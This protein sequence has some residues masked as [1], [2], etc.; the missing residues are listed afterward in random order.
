MKVISIIN[1]KGGVGKTTTAICLAAGLANK[2][3]KILLVDLDP[4]SSLTLSLGAMDTERNIYKVFNE[5]LKFSEVIKPYKNFHLVTSDIYLAGIERRPELDTY[6]VI[7]ESLGEINDFDYVLIDCPPSLGILT[8]NSLVSS[9]YLLIPL[10]T[11]YLAVRGLD[12]LIHTYQHTKKKHNQKLEIMGVV[13]TMFD[14]RRSLDK[15]TI[16]TL[17]KDKIHKFNTIIRRSVDLAEAPLKQMTIFDYH[18]EGRGASDYND[19]TKE[20]L[21]WLK[22][23]N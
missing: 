11:E 1:Q 15:V 12:D 20:V 9:D 5:E 2:K 3:K 23:R 16:E 8:M 21:K 7:R 6:F 4:Q 19:L 17:K 18:N 13:F 22:S 14:Q 10:Q